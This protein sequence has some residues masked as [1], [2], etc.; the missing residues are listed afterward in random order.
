MVRKRGLTR[1]AHSYILAQQLLVAF[2]VFGI[3]RYAIDRA[4]STALRRIEMPHT[5]GAAQRVDFVDQFPR[6]NCLIGTHRLAHI[7]IDALIGNQ[8]SHV[9]DFV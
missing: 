1:A 6:V 7:T 9:A 3:E 8:Q 4:Y 2:H 5:L